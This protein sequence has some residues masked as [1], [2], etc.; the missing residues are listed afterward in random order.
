MV[1]LDG[2][3]ALGVEAID[4]REARITREIVLGTMQQVAVKEEP[5]ARVDFHVAHSKH[6][7]NMLHPFRI[8]TNLSVLFH[9]IDAS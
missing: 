9:V 4:Y 6:G 2:V 1:L 7:T 8:S 5:V 3:V